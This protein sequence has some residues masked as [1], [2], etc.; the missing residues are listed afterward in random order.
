MMDVKVVC[1]KHGDKYP[2]Y[3][4]NRLHN[5]VKRHLQHPHEF[6]CFTEDVRGIESGI[7]VRWL[8]EESL[9]GWWW[10]TYLFKPGQFANGATILFF[11]LDMVI[12]NGLD[13]LLNYRPQ[14]FVGLRD[15]SRAFHPDRNILG[16]AVLRWRAGN[17]TDI[18]TGLVNDPTVTVRHRGDQDWIWDLYK[19]SMVF[20]PDAWIRSYKW[21]VR[22]RRELVGKREQTRFQ[23]VRDPPIDPETSVLAF[24]GFPKLEAVQDPVIVHNWQ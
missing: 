5:M 8:G 20:F 15:V 2:A 7:S 19:D 9:T 10:K 4:V 14:H 24:H 3:Y 22:T 18:W 16:S 1:V 12:V 21:E 6:I 11:D 23:A 13:K 17:H